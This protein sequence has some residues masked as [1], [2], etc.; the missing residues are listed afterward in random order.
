MTL[1]FLDDDCAALA[2]LGEALGRHLGRLCDSWGAGWAPSH[3]R[4]EVREVLEEE[5]VRSQGLIAR[6]PAAVPLEEVD[7]VIAFVPDAGRLRLR[8]GV[9]RVDWRLPH[10]ASAPPAERLEAYRAARDEISRR[11]QALLRE[12]DP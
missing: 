7:V 2:P 4:A 9:R 11:L 6:E 5:G 12:V 3:V 1:L 10:P 8:P